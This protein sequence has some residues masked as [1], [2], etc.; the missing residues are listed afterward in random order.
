MQKSVRARRAEV[1]AIGRLGRVLVV[2][3]I[4]GLIAGI[5]GCKSNTE[6]KCEQIADRWV[7][8]YLDEKARADS[9]PERGAA[10]TGEMRRGEFMEGLRKEIVD[11]CVSSMTSAQRE[12]AMRANTQ[13]DFRACD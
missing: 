11:R 10:V 2:A 12:C 8:T 1:V 13:A 7:Y 4:A 3:L 5:A 6:R 9:N